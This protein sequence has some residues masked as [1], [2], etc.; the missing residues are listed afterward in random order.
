M[1]NFEGIK[2]AV[3]E[4]DKTDDFE[5]YVYRFD[6]PN[7]MSYIGRK[8]CEVL[9]E[10]VEGYYS[11]SEN[12]EFWKDFYQHFDDIKMRILFA[13]K[14]RNSVNVEQ[15]LLTENNTKHNDKFYNL[16]ASAGASSSAIRLG[17]V[18][19][20]LA[21]IDAGLY[22]TITMS[23]ASYF[24][25][26]KRKQLDDRN[27]DSNHV[28]DLKE[29]FEEQGEFGD[30][31]PII[32][33]E[34]KSKTHKYMQIGGNHTMAAVDE[35]VGNGTDIDDITCIVLPL[36]STKKLIGVNSLTEFDVE[37]LGNALNPRPKK[38]ARASDKATLVRWVVN[39]CNK[40]E[41]LGSLSQTRYLKEIQNCTNKEIKG[42]I[43]SANTLMETEEAHSVLKKNGMMFKEYKKEELEE[44]MAETTITNEDKM[45]FGFKTSMG[46][47]KMDQLNQRLIDLHKSCKG[48]R[49][50]LNIVT[51]Y[52][53]P[54]QLVDKSYDEFAKYCQKQIK[55]LSKLMNFKYTVETLTHETP[56]VR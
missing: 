54:R 16:S 34:I 27:I 23:H 28:A 5:A 26:V 7:G 43:N 15:E 37:T 1:Y 29:V 21:G 36:K 9:G 44:I 24:E 18:N 14:Q 31:D 53:N 42:I 25:N 48:E 10:L 2:S 32:L 11:S 4:C 39:S 47:W 41:E 50:T 56:R 49:F 45:M 38:R 40:G 3:W 51:Y 52:S 6:F 30:F 33:L 22:K 20:I 55:Y 17:L 19:R 35:V 13:G 12:K 8:D 46:Y